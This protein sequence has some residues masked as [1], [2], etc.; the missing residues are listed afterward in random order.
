M[1][2][3]EENQQKT[4]NISLNDDEL[5]PV[6]GGGENASAFPGFFPNIQPVTDS[7]DEEPKDGGV[8]YSW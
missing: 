8:T 6:S 7:D 3:S 2:P 1:K 4:K 5:N